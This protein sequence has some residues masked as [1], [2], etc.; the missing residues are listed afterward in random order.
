LLDTYWAL[1][2]PYTNG[3]I[4]LSIFLMRNFF[5][6]LPTMLDDAA[7]ID[8]AS[9]WQIYRMV[10]LPLSKPVLSTAALISA[11]GIW[12]EFLLALVFIRDDA[13]RTLPLGILRFQN[14]AA[15][16]YP[17]LMAGDIISV[18]PIVILFILLQR[19]F[20]RGVTTGAFK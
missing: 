11:L 2:S 6:D 1:I 10:I 7:R 20:I 9:H 8:G 17:Q 16:N 3:V 15:I 13:L 19:T 5:D 14:Q 4:P 12:N 18:L